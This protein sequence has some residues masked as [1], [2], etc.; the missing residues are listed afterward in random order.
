MICVLGV[1]KI[2]LIYGLPLWNQFSLNALKTELH[3]VH[4]VY[5]NHSQMP[6][7]SFESNPFH[8]RSYCQLLSIQNVTRCDEKGMHSPYE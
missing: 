4:T 6:S 2:V 5:T 1:R 7:H 8:Q 3:L